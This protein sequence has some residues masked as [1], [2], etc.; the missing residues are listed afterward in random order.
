MLLC[1]MAM[2]CLAAATAKAP[3]ANQRLATEGQALLRI[4]LCAVLPAMLVVGAVRADGYAKTFLIG[5]FFAASAAATMA[6]YEMYIYLRVDNEDGLRVALGGLWEQLPRYRQL[7]AISWLFIPV[8]GLACV[9]FHRLLCLGDAGSG[10]RHTL[11]ERQFAV[12]LSTLVAVAICLAAA[13][14]ALSPAQRPLANLAQIALRVTIFMVFPAVLTTGVVHGAGYFRMFCLGCL[15][16]AALGFVAMCEVATAM[17]GVNLLQWSA[18]DLSEWSGD[19]YL[20]RYFA[21]ANLS[22]ATMFGSACLFLHWL[23]RLS[24]PKRTEE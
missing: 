7:F 4:V 3:P 22:V 14:V 15:F 16:P 1:V 24:E 18:L 8:V 19:Q 5:G 17:K 9:S 6:C 20:E 21:I 12:R 13:T 11:S 2:V 23:F 10:E